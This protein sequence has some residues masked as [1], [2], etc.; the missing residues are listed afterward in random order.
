MFPTDLLKLLFGRTYICT[1]LQ[2]NAGENRG[3]RIVATTTWLD[4]RST[5][6]KLET[7]FAKSFS[8]TWNRSGVVPTSPAAM[9]ERK[10]EFLVPPGLDL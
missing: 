10:R 3:E 8:G 6:R 5:L 1:P 9:A 2:G 4:D 7:S